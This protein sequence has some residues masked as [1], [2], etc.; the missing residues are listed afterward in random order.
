MKFAIALAVVV[1]SAQAQRLFCENFPTAAGD[2]RT[3]Q[4]V[5]NTIYEWYNQ[6]D[7]EQANIDAIPVCQ[8]THLTTFRS[9]INDTSALP[10]DHLPDPLYI[11]N[12]VLANTDGIT[13]SSL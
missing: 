7:R 3:W 1:A 2:T 5:N 6:I 4:Q 8:S 13:A 12:L 9:M 10:A 11:N